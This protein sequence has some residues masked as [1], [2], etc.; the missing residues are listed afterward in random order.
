MAVQPIGESNLC[1]PVWTG[2]RVRRHMAEMLAAG[3]S[4]GYFVAVDCRL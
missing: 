4:R 1:A 3:E 2:E